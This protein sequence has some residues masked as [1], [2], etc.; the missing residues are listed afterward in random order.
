VRS[1]FKIGDT[2]TVGNIRYRVVA[3]TRCAGDKVLQFSTGYYDDS[4]VLRW[5][6]PPISHTLI[7]VNFKFEVEEN[8]YGANGRVVIGQGGKYLLD[9][10]LSSSVLGWRA[11]ADKIAE[12]VAAK[13][14]RD[15]AKASP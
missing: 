3:G 11:V 5:C 1:E 2:W 10:I 4:S 12:Q 7:L 8:N 6:T 13:A 15:Q 14:R 9:R